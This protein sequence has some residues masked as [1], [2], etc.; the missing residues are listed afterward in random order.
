M[1]VAGEVVRLSPT[2]LANHLACPHTTNLN[3]AVA[4]GGP[5]PPYHYDSRLEAM[6]LRGETHEVRYVE[7]LQRQG[8]RV[9]RID[10]TDRDVQ[11]TLNAMQSGFD[12]IVQASLV[13]G[14]WQGRADILQRVEKPSL[15]GS[16]SYE[17][18]DTKLS[19]ETKAGTILQLCVYSEILA[20]LQGIL[21]EHMHVVVPGRD[22][23]PETYRT[24]EYFAYYSHVKANL[25]TAVEPGGQRQTYPEPVPHC[26]V[27]RWWQSC[28]RRRREDD[29]LSLVAGISRLQQQELKSRQIHTLESLGEMP[30]PL[31]WKPGR[32][33]AEG[34]EKVREQARI[35][36]SSRR[37]GKPEYELLALEA[38]R[39]LARLPEPTLWDVFFDF[40][41]DPF[42]ETGGLE[43]LWGWVTC[44]SGT[45][46]YSHRWSLNRTDERAA[47]ESF[48]DFVMD[49][50]SAHP[51]LHIFHY[52]P[53]E[54]AALK[55][56][57]GRYA[58][59]EAEIDRMLR[60]GLFVD[61]YSVVRQALRAGVEKYSIKD[62]EVFFNYT[63]E[64]PLRDA[65]AALR[66]VEYAVEL[67]D[68]SGIQQTDLDA[69]RAYNADDCRAT[70]G[71][72]DW[73]E[74][75]RKGRV[76]TRPS[77]TPA[78]PPESVTQWA[79]KVAP[80]KERL[81]SG[82]PHRAQWL[83]A[84]MLEFHRRESK[85]K[86][87]EFFRLADLGPDELMD[88]RDAISGLQ[89][90]GSVE[91]K[92]KTPTHRYTFPFQEVSL[93]IGDALQVSDDE[94]IG[95][96]A[97]IHTSECW[98]H[99]KKRGDAVEKHP[100]AVFSKDIVRS[101]ELEEA[102]LRMG[103]WVAHNSID[104]DG[105]YRAGRDLLMGRAPRLLGGARIQQ[106]GEDSL[107]AAR[108][109]VAV[110]DHTALCIQ[111]P[112]G[113]GKTY[114]AA[115]MAVDLV[116]LGKKVGV[117]ALSHKV[118]RNLL[119]AIVQA[120]KK[121]GVHLESVQKVKDTLGEDACI[122]ES[123]DN[124]AVRT[125]LAE[126]STQVVGGTAW[127]WAREDF[128]EAVDVLFLD[129]AGQFPLA[130]AAAI[131]QGTRS[132]V[133]VGDPQQLESPIQGTHPEGVEVSALHH[134]LAGKKTIPPEL[135]LFIAETRRLAPGIC[136]F[137]SEQFYEGRLGPFSGTERQVLAGHPI[138]HGAG[139][140]FAPTPHTG[141][142][143]T[144]PEE[145]ERVRE[146]VDSLTGPGVT[147]TDSDGNTH[148][149][150]QKDILVVA[151]YNAHVAALRRALPGMAI[152]TVDKFQGQEAAVVV[153]SMATSSPEDAPRGM[154][155]LYSLNRLNVATSRARCACI[156]VANPGLL[157]PDCRTP[158]QMRLANSF[159]RYR[160]IACRVG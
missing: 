92:G 149:L 75:L 97:D 67:G 50:W 98:V 43:F 156:L 45:D 19:R 99:I 157:E 27:C 71:L 102:L 15:L 96:V 56:L 133:L 142:R 6:Q 41:G 21:P 82:D 123:K 155:F 94:V 64:I 81:L 2:D 65:S 3:L 110:L 117:C 143:N 103:S 108:R 148:P 54:P 153:Y 31:V 70:R 154:D 36:L 107:T 61:L 16:W 134:V 147:W 83:L 26:D 121:D 138:F 32:G 73:L 66:A 77:L 76:E 18:Q 132:V 5:P 124:A 23:V 89:F 7:H 80:V 68:V 139:L 37:A 30:L 104:P 63:R 125:A 42:V 60:A 137:T 93:D 1:V 135:G 84:Q 152:G 59:R 126:G 57:M 11:T 9:H 55:R 129:E 146:L 33:S 140:W 128:F 39:G 51:T 151:P 34:I 144:S 53:Y 113:T 58:S 95:T 114:T 35:Q 85:V 13:A 130:N 105:P 90:V 112:P 87:W 62:L 111:G 141:N 20:T 72:R 158:T 29:H 69:V 160:E 52:A 106:T 8:L 49:R 17:P 136:R 122:T 14:R 159:C 150:T 127:L 119:K 46:H 40:E 78:D 88:E 28:D 79:A 120:A 101:E 115:R 145:V 4:R 12:I 118:V 86:W 44:E 100:E 22:F 91:G 38:D 109:L 74:E 24:S 25:E 10:E 116:K 131:S 47:F 48:V